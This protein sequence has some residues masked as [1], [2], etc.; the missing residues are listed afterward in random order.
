MEIR[1][2]YPRSLD[3]TPQNPRR[4]VRTEDPHLPLPKN[5]LELPRGRRI[6]RNDH[7]RLTTIRTKD[8]S[9]E[10]LDGLLGTQGMLAL[11]QLIQKRS[12]R[13]SRLEVFLSL[14]RIDVGRIDMLGRHQPN[15]LG[16][17]RVVLLR[18]RWVL[19]QLTS[20]PTDD[21]ELVRWKVLS[22]TRQF[23]RLAIGLGQPVLHLI[24]VA[25]YRLARSVISKRDTS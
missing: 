18:I 14:H 23:V 3:H 12:T 7:A 20:L 19:T 21:D 4:N 10:T 16:D 2:G 15:Q 1:I 6:Q 24:N 5:R 25:L 11:G 9:L 17:P 22:K 13:L 8:R